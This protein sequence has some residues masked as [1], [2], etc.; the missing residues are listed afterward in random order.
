MVLLLFVLS[1]T[2]PQTKM[3]NKS[4]L[5]WIEWD[6]NRMRYCQKRC[7]HEYKD[8]PCLKEFFKL[9]YNDYFCECGQP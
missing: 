4:G 2:C 3:V 1:S 6:Y 9:G 5:P 8:A 7:P